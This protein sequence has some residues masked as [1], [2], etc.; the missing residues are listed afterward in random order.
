MNVD[1]CQHG[2]DVSWINTLSPNVTEKYMP[3]IL[4]VSRVGITW[5]Q[6]ISGSQFTGKV[7]E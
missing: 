3:V 6:A 1:V 7:L 5:P 4:E 2:D